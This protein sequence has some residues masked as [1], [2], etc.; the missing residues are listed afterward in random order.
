MSKASIDL[1]INDGFVQRE[2]RTTITHKEYVMAYYNDEND[3]D[4]SFEL[5]EREAF[6][7][8][9][10]DEALAKYGVIA[11]TPVFH[12]PSFLGIKTF[13]LSISDLV[14]AWQV[15]KS[16]HH[17]GKSS[18]VRIKRSSVF[19]IHSQSLFMALFERNSFSTMPW[20]V[21]SLPAKRSI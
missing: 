7:G 16:F 13:I 4:L 2:I 3:L 20:L 18:A 19:E 21:I 14:V 1:D 6:R 9:K 5:Y 17:N 11:N 15:T 10:H 12:L 8:R